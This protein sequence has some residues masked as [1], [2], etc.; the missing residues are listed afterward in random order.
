MGLPADRRVL[1][2]FAA[3]VLLGGTNLVLVVVT[4]RELDPL[5]AAGLRF[6]AAAVLAF[7]AVALLRL[8]VPR[9]RVLLASIAYG[10]LAFFL[11][12]ALFY[13]GTREVPAGIASVV[14]GAVPL[15]TFYLAL[16][17]RLERFRLRGLV[18][19]CL[20]IVGIAV[21]SA[22]SP[23]SLP[24]VPLLAVFGSAATAG[25]AAITI[26]RIRDVHPL[27]VNAI[28]L[29][30]GGVLLLATSAV[31]GESH[32]LPSS[33]GV[34]AALAVMVASTPLL[35]VLFVL[36]VQRWSASAASYQFAMFP[37]VSIVLG[38]IL[39]DEQVSAALLVGA[40]LVILGVYVGALAPDRARPPEPAVEP[41][42]ELAS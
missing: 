5:W 16:A 33:P 42:A 20:A 27:T 35:F 36:V 26:R 32:A 25:Q 23:G 39:L 24:V 4:T 15:L 30:S 9:G 37:L 19:A 2:A 34:W 6:G 14:M 10:A 40:P 41:S 7:A 22:R 12:F 13:W 1:A 31:A 18:G 21:I 28:G 29:A 8:P 11:G 38:S 17:Q 3:V